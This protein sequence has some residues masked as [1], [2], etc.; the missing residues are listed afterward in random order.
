[1]RAVV[2]KFCSLSPK[3]LWE[4]IQAIAALVLSVIHWASS[5]RFHL[6]NKPIAE[7][8]LVTSELGD[9]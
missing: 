8:R 9:A 7:K 3:I 1:M 5:L 2:F 4:E 6:Q